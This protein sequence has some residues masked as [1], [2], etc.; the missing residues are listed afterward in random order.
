M[1]GFCF[2]IVLLF[3][4]LVFFLNGNALNV[5]NFLTYPLATYTNHAIASRG[6][7]REKCRL[8][9]CFG[10]SCLSSLFERIKVFFIISV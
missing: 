2:I 7:V 3:F 10:L 6:N 1:G 4:F 9:S 5:V 8:V